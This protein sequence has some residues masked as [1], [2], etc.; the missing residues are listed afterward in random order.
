MALAMM[1]IGKRA[2]PRASFALLGLGLL[3][4]ASP[5]GTVA[6]Q[7]L[8]GGDFAAGLESPDGKAPPRP[9]WWRVEGGARV[10]E[11]AGAHWLALDPG[12]VARQ[13]FAAYAP[14]AAGLVVAGRVRGA[15]RVTIVDGQGGRATFEVGDAGDADAFEVRGE[16]IAGLL[17]RPIVP[18]FELEL[19]AR[20]DA[21]VEWTALEARVPLPLVERAE[22]RAEIASILG[23]I[24]DTWTE[25]AADVEGRATAFLSAQFDAVTGERLAA[26]PG[27]LLPLQIFLA[28]ALESH[29]DPKWSGMLDGFLADYL[30]LGLH[31]TT[32]LPRRWDGTRDV[33]L[34][35]TYVQI[36]PDL[37]FLIG[38]AERGPEAWRARARAAAARIGE[39][40]L[41]HGVLPD[42][43]VA[44]EY[45]PAD[46]AISTNVPPLRRLDVPCQL[47]RLA[48]LLGDERYLR[49]ARGAVLELEYTHAWPGTWDEIDPGFDDDFG[50][51]GARA[52]EMLRVRPGE[53]AFRDLFESGWRRYAPLWRDSTRFGGTVAADQVRCWALLADQRAASGRSSPRSRRGSTRPRARTSRA[54]S[55]PAAR[56]G[57]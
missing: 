54:S 32:G 4:G 45:R 7:L 48:A 43:S 10:V 50:L 31:G 12:A 24:L 39:T 20:G 22:L 26:I 42:G 38:I 28:E 55:T 33:P 1:L 57:T 30:E 56:G 14:T 51:Y 29:A 53:R 18:R 47:A 13:P 11:R 6:V 15:G 49:A 21:T 2:I 3:T 16:Q 41:D 27:G 23:W 40:V 34:D 44:A 46:A 36:A 25:R 5:G 8:D 9:P 52:V 35:A 19:A 37:S 17:G